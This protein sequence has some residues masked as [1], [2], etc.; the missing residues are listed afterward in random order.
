MTLSSS[1]TTEILRHP[2]GGAPIA[3]LNDKAPKWVVSVAIAALTVGLA[4]VGVGAYAL[5]TTPAQA[6]GPRGPVGPAGTTGEV[7]PP[8]PAGERGATGPTG[9]AGTVSATSIVAS[10]ALKSPPEPRGRDGAS[11]QDVLSEW[12]GSFEWWC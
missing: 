10:T 12:K 2:E 9:P 11:R 5:A 6:S 7:G 1:P 3:S 8:G 4:G